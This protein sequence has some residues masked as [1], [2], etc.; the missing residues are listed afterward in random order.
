MKLL[1][2]GKA[3]LCV[4]TILA[5]LLIFSCGNDASCTDG[6]QNQFE[7]GI[8]CD[9]NG[10]ICPF[11]D[12]SLIVDPVDT[13]MQDTMM[14]DT[15]MQDTMTNNTGACANGGLI[16]ATI[17]GGTWESLSAE[18]ENV[19]LFD[20]EI[21]ADNGTS[22]MTLRYSGDKVPGTTTLSPT[23][24]AEMI[25]KADLFSFRSTQ[26]AGSGELNI[27]EFDTTNKTIT[28]TFNFVGY[29]VTGVNSKSI[30]DGKFNALPY[31]D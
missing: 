10:I 30:T 6:I 8:D 20:I 24:N 11:C 17:D 15:M 31:V 26:G 29:D 9:I 23:S 4:L 22:E 2:P 25:Y 27:T 5:S 13:M 12:T 1:N 19:G 18:D 28:G 21:L 7:T 14:Q 16:C 3:F